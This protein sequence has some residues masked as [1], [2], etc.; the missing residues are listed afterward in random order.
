M[1][2]LAPDIPDSVNE[3][4]RLDDL[5]IQQSAYGIFIPIV[6]GIARVSGNVI[7]ATELEEEKV[8]TKEKQGGK[9][10]IGS[11]TTTN[12]T[13][14]YYANFALAF[15][16]GEAS[17]LGR[18]WADGKL[19]WDGTEIVP[20]E[21]QTAEEQTSKQDSVGY[22]FRFY[23]GS[24]A[25]ELDPLIDLKT[26]GLSPSFKGICYMVFERLPLTNFNNR[27]PNITAEITFDASLTIADITSRILN[28]TG[29]PTTE[30]NVAQLTDTIDGYVIDSHATAKSLIEP[31]S[32]LFT[33]NFVERDRVLLAQ[34]QGGTHALTIPES[35]LLTNFQEPEVV[36]TLQQTVEAPAV[37][38]LEYISQALD[39]G[40]AVAH[41]RRILIPN[42]SFGNNYEQQFPIISNATLM[43]QRAEILLYDLWI[44]RYTFIVNLP[45]SYLQL[46]PT[47][48]IRLQLDSG[49]LFTGSISDMEIGADLSVKLTLQ[50][51][52]QTVYTSN[53]V[54]DPGHV[55]VQVQAQTGASELFVLDIPYIRDID[56]GNDSPITYWMG[57]PQSDYL[58]GGGILYQSLDDTAF[59]EVDRQS[60]EVAYGTLTTALPNP[61]GDPT[62]W[63][64]EAISITM[65]VTVGV[66]QFESITTAQLNE[67]YNLLAV[68]KSNGDTELLQFQ[69]VAQN[70]DDNP[71]ILTL[72]NILRGRRGTDTFVYNHSTGERAILLTLDTVQI[73]NYPLAHLNTL[74]Y[75]RLVTNG[76]L[77]EETD[78]DQFTLAANC[79][80]PYAP[81]LY[82]AERLANGD[83]T[84]GWTRRTRFGATPTLV[85]LNEERELYEIEMLNP[86]T[87]AILR[88]IEDLDTN[89]YNYTL[90]EQITDGL[91]ANTIFEL[92][93]YQISQVVGRGF[94]HQF[95]TMI[96]GVSP[97]TTN[98]TL[99]VQTTNVIV[100][101]STLTNEIRTVN[102]ILL[103]NGKVETIITSIS[104]WATAVK[105]NSETRAYEVTPG[106]FSFALAAVH[107]TENRI[108]SLLD[109]QIQNVSGSATVTKYTFTMTETIAPNTRFAILLEDTATDGLELEDEEFATDG[110]VSTSIDVEISVSG[111]GETAAS[112]SVTREDASSSLNLTKE[113]AI[114]E[115]DLND[116]RIFYGVNDLNNNTI[117]P[118]NALFVD[119]VI[120]LADR[121]SIA[122]AAFIETGATSGLRVEIT[123]QQVVPA[124]QSLDPA[125]AIPDTPNTPVLDSAIFSA[126][127]FTT[128]AVSGTDVYIWRISTDSTVDE[129]DMT[130]ETI[131]SRL[132]ISGLAPS[133]QR[134]ISVAARNEIGI[135]G[136]SGVA[137]GTT[138]ALPP[139]GTPNT[140]TLQSRTETSLVFTVDAVDSATSYVWRISSDSTIDENDPT[141]ETTQPSLTITGLMNRDQRWVT[142]AAKNIGGTSNFSNEATG[143][144][145]ATLTLPIDI[146]TTLLSRELRE[147]SVDIPAN[148][149]FTLSLMVTNRAELTR[150]RFTAIFYDADGTFLHSQT[151][152]SNSDQ[153]YTVT[154][155]SAVTRMDISNI[156][157]FD[158]NVRVQLT[159]T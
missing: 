33:F 112:G 149:E 152:P 151:I 156:R 111:G 59:I 104:V 107:A 150:P 132:E 130:V 123:G 55:N 125:T 24:E 84:L 44:K 15:G 3:G 89:T 1:G 108:T 5:N 110:S 124:T 60:T 106:S 10:G 32:E 30:Y 118:D 141:M 8:V 74:L 103:T 82:T 85:P 75:Y 96:T 143:V 148:T 19:V 25:Q 78:S 50:Q 37:L 16:R 133:T 116:K 134:W 140:P 26:G 6:Y 79:L 146:S 73:L 41:A 99:S 12:I 94:A 64:L 127:T 18:V 153:T 47:D 27:L 135:S 121:Q 142:V 126:L 42:V 87:N 13:W 80:K 138:V 9:G 7:W 2:F 157:S 22:M 51:E 86:R 88:T 70:D 49:L 105:I 129:N 92:R 122:A 45:K 36:E 63:S 34:K 56:A 31:L 72:S 113:D 48:I 28:E 97:L 114:T 158:M 144:A 93:I 119:K 54:A 120:K 81:V 102:G 137:T 61:V 68:T 159:A 53:T 115:V 62:T 109:S 65:N 21:G 35:K 52:E 4:S 23:N 139:P 101:G 95:N 43:K 14:N 20:L 76:F 69:T 128:N 11:S 154:L 77:L 66:D 38:S 17:T 145:M 67:G 98:S 117:L 147:Y 136:F 90:A 83:I 58:W 100:T 91:Q 71:N 39:Y 57:S 131:N 29:I 40:Q 46:D 155:T